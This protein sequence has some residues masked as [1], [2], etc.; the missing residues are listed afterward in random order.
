MSNERP[1]AELR[2]SGLLWLINRV[3]FHPQGL[4]LAVVEDDTG[5]ITGWSLV[6]DGNEP[7][8]FAPEDE[9]HLFRQAHATLNA[10]RV[11]DPSQH[12][13]TRP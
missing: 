1:L 12:P 7:M 10:A 8:W 9:A 6:G 4:A 3:V 2:S 13:H 5:T 11:T